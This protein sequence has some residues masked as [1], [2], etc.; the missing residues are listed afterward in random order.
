MRS[1]LALAA[2]AAVLA[3]SPAAAVAESAAAALQAFGLVG[4]WSSDC[5]GPFRTI[6]A[7]PAG[8]PPTVRVI[9]QGRE[10]ASS[11]IREILGRS[12]DR[13]SWTSVIKTWSLP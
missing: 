6:Y 7:A 9:Q 11:E 10:I 12:G 8:G 3:L 1:T 2:V 4:T 5:S 13:I